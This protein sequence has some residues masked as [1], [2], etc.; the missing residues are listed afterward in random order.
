MKDLRSI[1]EQYMDAIPRRDFGK[2]R[3]MLHP[4]YSYT[5]SDGQRQEGPDAGIAVLEMYTNAFPDMTIDIR[6]MNV[7]GD[8]VLTEFIARGTHRG[9]LIGIA[10]TNRQI[11]MPI[12]NI[13]EMRDG[14]IYAEREYFDTLFMMQQLGVEVGHAHA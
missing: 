5:G 9:E 1:V 8:I 10:P 12:C 7:A 3:Q 4:Q 11:E 2:I 14:K 6:H 13:I